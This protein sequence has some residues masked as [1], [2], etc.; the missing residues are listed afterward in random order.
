MRGTPFFFCQ[1]SSS[2]SRWGERIKRTV[3]Q[4]V[5]KS[6]KS[7]RDSPWF[8]SRTPDFV[9]FTCSRIL[10]ITPEPSSFIQKCSPKSSSSLPPSPLL[11]PPLPSPAGLVILAIPVPF[12]AVSLHNP[13]SPPHRSASLNPLFRQPD[14]LF[15][16]ARSGQPLGTSGPQ[17]W[18]DHWPDRP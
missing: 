6:Y 17:S 1:T 10:Q 4:S 3:R 8:F 16:Y 18:P 9:T 13:V 15:N 7:R 12:S 14:V 2:V 5:A 11:S